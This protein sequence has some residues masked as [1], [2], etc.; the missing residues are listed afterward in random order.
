MLVLDFRVSSIPHVTKDEC[1]QPP[2]ERFDTRNKR[3]GHHTFYGLLLL[4][5]MTGA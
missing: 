4:P 3:I 2:L 5:T 1:G